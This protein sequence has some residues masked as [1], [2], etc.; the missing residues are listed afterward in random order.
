MEERLLQGPIARPIY[1]IFIHLCSLAAFAITVPIFYTYFLKALKF[2]EYGTLV[3]WFNTSWLI[4][5][6]FVMFVL[7][8]F[9][10]LH[11]IGRH[12]IALSKACR[13]IK[14]AAE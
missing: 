8:I 2:P 4:E 13:T 9:H 12:A 10:T 11:N 3:C 7:S 6:M 14:G 5:I 1:K